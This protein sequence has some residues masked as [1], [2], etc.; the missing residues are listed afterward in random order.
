[1]AHHMTLLMHINLYDHCFFNV[2]LK[3]YFLYNLNKMVNSLSSNFQILL[4]IQICNDF[5]Y[6]Q[7]NKINSNCPSQYLNIISNFFYLVHK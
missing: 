6:F 5:H 1:M 4:S 2:P 7:A 3:K